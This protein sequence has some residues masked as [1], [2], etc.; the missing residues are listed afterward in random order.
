MTLVRTGALLFTFG[1]TLFY[2]LS[3]VAVRICFRKEVDEPT[4]RARFLQT[5]S[6]LPLLLTTMLTSVGLLTAVHCPLPHGERCP[7]PFPHLC[8]HSYPWVRLVPA[9]HLLE[10]LCVALLL[11]GAL[12]Y[13]SAM[14]AAHMLPLP[15]ASVI[16]GVRLPRGLKGQSLRLVASH[17]AAHVMRGDPLASAFV[18]L[19]KALFFWL[20]PA[21]WL[22]STWRNYAEQAASQGA[23]RVKASLSQ[24][25]V[26]S[27]FFLFALLLSPTFHCAAEALLG[28]WP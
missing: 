16:C 3:A 9:L 14:I 15:G 18:D 7:L 1:G 4:L 12:G 26:S 19:G 2:T 13:V 23:T 8:L 28:L 5:A 21:R 22:S 25:L 27:S 24:N 17:E 11:I 6:T 20:P 10:P